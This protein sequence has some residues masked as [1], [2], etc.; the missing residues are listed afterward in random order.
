MQ[1]RYTK[2]MQ[3]W[4]LNEPVFFQ[5]L[6]AHELSA[7][8]HIS[9]PLRSG[10]KMIEYNPDIVREMTDEALEEAFRAEAVRILLKHPYERRPDGC[11][12]RAMGLGSNLTIGDNY[13]HPRLRIETPES[14]GMKRNMPYEWYARE[15]EQRGP[16]GNNGAAGGNG[17]TDSMD[18]GNDGDGTD[19]KFDDL[20]GLWEEDDMAVQL[21]NGI[22]SSSKDW[23]SISGQ[24]AEKL[25][26]TLQAKINWRT[27]F[28]GFRA[29]ILSSK[30][31]LTRMKPNRRSGFE[32]MGSLRKFD[33][34]LL[35]AVDTSGSIST[36]SLMYFYGVINSAFKYGFESIDVIQF[37]CGVSAV[38]QLNRVVREQLVFGRGGTS[39]QEP[40]DYAHENRYDG[41]IML[42]DGYAPAPRIPDRFRTSLLWVCENEECYNHHRTWMEN[43][44]RVCIM[45]I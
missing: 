44:G 32:A 34:K 43:S 17:G 18:M 9:C 21:I 5:I 33:T 37:D 4:F 22:I 12:Q 39:F 2:I 36:K 20:A 25:K 45:Q 10:K 31:R 6:C 14:M 8:G 1:E 23:G 3:N 27:V 7:N 24:F 19:R 38:E 13:R 28:S 40:I 41:L 16:S 30:R 35:I 11:S 26:A 15:V 29:S 42:T